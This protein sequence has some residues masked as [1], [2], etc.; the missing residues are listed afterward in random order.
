[1]STE[2]TALVPSTIE[3][4]KALATTLAK[5]NLLPADLVGKEANVFMAIMSGRELG[6]PPMAS[7][8]GI[9]IIKGK[10]ILHADTMVG[11]VLSRG[12]CEYFQPVESTA[13]SATYVTKR[14]GMPEP[15]RC[16]FTIAE[17]KL[18]GLVDRKNSDGSPSNYIKYPR[19]M[20]KARCKA[21]LARD[22][23]PDVIGGCYLP[24]EADEI[25]ATPDAPTTAA[26]DLAG[27]TAP[28][29]VERE[30][31]A[32]DAEIVE[33]TKPTTTPIADAADLPKSTPAPD[34]KPAG[35]STARTALEA[36]EA[37]GLPLETVAEIDLMLHEIEEAT[38]LDAM[39][40]VGNICSAARKAD[41]ERARAIT[42]MV[43][44]RFQAKYRELKAAATK[45]ARGSR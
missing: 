41:D 11:I 39:T 34:A 33:P 27:F 42:S 15:V 6:L 29:R 26:P 32:V 14:K 40:R 44:P 2:L 30:P 7:I 24:D 43:W 20:L 13:E 8:R 38:T 25:Q 31:D 10:P 16:T 1:M 35:D 36:L 19:A 5:S 21:M 22:V 4:T 37:F 28:P 12:V 45:T 18:A 23:Y 9:S 17:A 3:E